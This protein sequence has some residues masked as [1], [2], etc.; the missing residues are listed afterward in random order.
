MEIE[1]LKAKLAETEKAHEAMKSEFSAKETG[2]AEEK[3]KLEASVKELSEKLDK[4]ESDTRK[5]ELNAYTDKLVADKKITPAA[6]ETVYAL[7]DVMA[8]GV[9]TYSD[10]PVIELFKQFVESLEVK[11]PTDPE[12]ETG[13]K[14]EKD[15]H[16]LAKEYAA[17]NG[18]DF[19]VA[20]KAVSKK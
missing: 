14:G 15:E 3:A 5:T 9:R 4:A 10:K 17:K 11:L 2:F 16:A 6:K 20:L 7:L 19:K 8:T 18:V 13:D 12:T 1:E